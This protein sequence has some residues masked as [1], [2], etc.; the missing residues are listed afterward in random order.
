MPARLR[1]AL[2]YDIWGCQFGSAGSPPTFYDALIDTPLVS[3]ADRPVLR[4]RMAYFAY[5]LTDPAVW[6]AERGYC[7][8]N[9]NM[10]VTW[11]IPRGLV[12]CTIPEHPMAKVWYREA[13]RIMERREFLKRTGPAVALAAATGGTGLIFHNRE[14]TRQRTIVTK[15]TSFEV[16]PDPTLPGVTLAR[17]EDPTHAL[18]QALDAIGGIRRFVKPGERVLLKINAAFAS[19]PSLGATSLPDLVKQL[20]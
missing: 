18:S 15:T 8:G 14:T 12:A 20:L 10:T 11:E 2:D 16:E 6:S 19:P 9:A 7:S 3:E 1:Q 13:E 17:N 5:R 4:A